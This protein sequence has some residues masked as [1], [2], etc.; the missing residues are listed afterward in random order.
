MGITFMRCADTYLQFKLLM[1]SNKNVNIKIINIIF[2]FKS[3][4]TN[5]FRK[6]YI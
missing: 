5:A 1:P 3:M 6:F 2:N 4:E